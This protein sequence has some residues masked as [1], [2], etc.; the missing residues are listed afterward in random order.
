MR[1]HDHRAGEAAGQRRR[2]FPESR[3]HAGEL[4]RSAVHPFVVEQRAAAA[5]DCSR[6]CGQARRHRDN[7]ER[8]A[9]SGPQHGRPGPRRCPP[10]VATRRR[11][12]RPAAPARA[13]R[14]RGPGGRPSPRASS[15]RRASP[16]RA[17]RTTS[18]PMLLG[19]KLL[20]KVATRNERSECPH[21]HVHDLLRVQQQPPA[22]GARQHHQEVQRERRSEP[23]K[24]CR[25]RIIPQARHVAA[26]DEQPQ[27]PDADDDL[28]E[29]DEPTTGGRWRSRGGWWIRHSQ[30]GDRILLSRVEQVPRTGILSIP[31]VRVCQSM[32][33]SAGMRV[34]AD[35]RA[36]VVRLDH[37]AR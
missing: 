6:P 2:R 16:C 19:R 5:A 35:C 24:R 17:I 7:R 27:Q 30:C 9:Q 1:L 36:R 37:R 10:C 4:L 8:A 34:S 31:H 3:E 33:V 13:G 29:Q 11:D 32:C 22:P 18:P 23:G 26:S 20:K 21:P 12:R 15:S 25:P 14:C 28:R